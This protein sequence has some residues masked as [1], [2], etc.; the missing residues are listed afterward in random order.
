MTLDGEILLWLQNNVRTDLLSKFFIFITRLG[1]GGMIWIAISLI[2]LI[3]KKTR[4]TGI[5][6]ALA[7]IL[8]LLFNNIILKN[9]FDRTRP[10]I[11]IDGL[12][13]LVTA[14]DASFP[15]GHTSSSFS[16]AVAIFRNLPKKYSFAA[17]ILAS[18]IAFSRLYLGVHYP[19]DIIGG[20]LTGVFSAV[21]S[22]IVINAVY[23]KFAEPSSK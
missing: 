9:I 7:L 20:I 3:P 5:I 13:N 2:L 12:D 4:K 19:S 17:I 23:K 16:A 1:N 10:F 18:L 14:K 21:V 15:S 6:C 8:S 11:S 22:Q